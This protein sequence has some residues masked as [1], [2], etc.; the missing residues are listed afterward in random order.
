MALPFRVMRCVCVVRGRGL[1][2]FV[3]LFLLVR[4]CTYLGEA[5]AALAAVAQDTDDAVAAALGLVTAALEMSPRVETAL[6]LR[7]RAPRA[8]ALPRCLHPWLEIDE[9]HRHCDQTGQKR[10]AN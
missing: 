4:F 9:A 1:I 8:Q 10:R 5:R 6:E 7:A 3:V 2:Y